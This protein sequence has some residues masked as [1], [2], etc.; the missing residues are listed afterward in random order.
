MEGEIEK[1]KDEGLTAKAN[2]LENMKMNQRVDH[3]KGGAELV[4][5]TRGSPT[6]L[7]LIIM[8]L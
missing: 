1:L 5:L 3:M 7:G 4:G 8:C 6:F 2:E